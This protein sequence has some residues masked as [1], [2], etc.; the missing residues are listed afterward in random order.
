MVVCLLKL[1]E[2][3]CKDSHFESPSK[4]ALISLTESV[5]KTIDD[6]IFGCGVFIDLQKTFDT[7]NHSILLKK[8]KTMVLG[9][10]H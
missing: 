1:S 8:W 5:K 6:G 4:H 9:A 10:L 3:T 2:S 7:V